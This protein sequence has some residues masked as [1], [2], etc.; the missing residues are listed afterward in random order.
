VKYEVVDYYTGERLEG[1]VFD[2]EELA[3]CFL[4]GYLKQ[5]MIDKV[6]HNKL[7]FVKK[8]NSQT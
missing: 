7:F 6:I 5:K 2:D 8:C 3:H 1:Q 4:R